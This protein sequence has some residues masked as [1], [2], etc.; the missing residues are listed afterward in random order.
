MDTKQTYTLDQIIE[1]FFD[2][3]EYT[4]EQKETV[5]AETGD[6]IM[7]GTILKLLNKSDEST[8]NKFADFIETNPS[9]D[10][11]TKFISDNFPN[12]QE[13][14]IEEVNILKSLGE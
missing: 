5:I 12:F 3:T 13:M 14:L 7:E 4:E 10:Q 6:I 2:L 11:M 9:D 1:E 8:Q